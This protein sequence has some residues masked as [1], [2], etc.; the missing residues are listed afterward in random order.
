GGGA[1]GLGD[2]GAVLAGVGV[3]EGLRAR[4]DLVGDAQQV[5]R[6][7]GG[8]Q[9]GPGGQGAAGGGDGEVEF[10]VGGRGDGTPGLPGGGVDDG[11]TP[12]VGGRAPG[13]VDVEV[14]DVGV[15]EVER[16]AA[17]A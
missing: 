8:A 3:G 10:P 9:R 14:L 2:G 6:P 17:G 13:A 12:P 1:H 7:F 16:G 15:G 11:V 5:L 4:L